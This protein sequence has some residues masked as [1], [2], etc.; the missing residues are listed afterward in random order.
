MYDS[1]TKFHSFEFTVVGFGH[2]INYR[3]LISQRKK[4]RREKEEEKEG[5]K[6]GGKKLSLVSS[7]NVRK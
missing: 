6:K 2:R 4:T 1:T 7:I 5:A 3:L